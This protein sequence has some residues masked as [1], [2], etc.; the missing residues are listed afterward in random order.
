MTETKTNFQNQAATIPN[1]ETQVDQMVNILLGR[2]QDTLP[3]TNE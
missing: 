2:Q 1:L 3:S